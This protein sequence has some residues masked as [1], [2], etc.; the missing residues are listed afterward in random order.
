MP[1]AAPYNRDEALDAAMSLFWKK[2]YH[3]TSLKDLEASLNM[4]PGSIY[5]AF[6]SKSNLYLLALERYF[7]SSKQS[8]LDIASTPGSPLDAL[9]NQMRIF[10]ALPPD[11][12]HAQSCMLVKTLIDTRSTDTEIAERAKLYVSDLCEIIATI[13]DQAINLGELPRDT[14]T[15]RLAR[16]YQASIMA[17]RFKTHQGFQRTQITELAEDFVQEFERLR[18]MPPPS[19]PR[20]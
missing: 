15:R 11:H 14:D 5:S 17:L 3:A 10:A 16:R 8:F 2:G 12:E 1:Q 18:C 9:L 6:S 13:F 7:E 20:L 19:T 4:K